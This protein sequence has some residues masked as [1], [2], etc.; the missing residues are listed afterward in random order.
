MPSLLGKLKDNSDNLL[1]TILICFSL[2][3]IVIAFCLDT[4]LDIVNGLETIIFHSDKLITDYVHIAGWGATFVNAG[5]LMLIAIGIIHIQKVPINGIAMAAIFLMGGFGMFGKNIVNI[6]NILLGTYLYSKFT[7]TKFSQYIF[8][9]FF[10][11]ALAPLVTE[12]IMFSDN[13]LMGVLIGVLIGFILPP[14]SRK[15]LQVHQGYNLSNVGFAA[16]LIGTI[17]VSMM[18][19]FNYN[20]ES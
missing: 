8:I 2:V 17:L 15:S 12:A 6:W 7:H 20:A 19:S 5:L 11:T 9:A 1:K 13:Y 16:G 18:R 3:F 14:V 10:G 4:P